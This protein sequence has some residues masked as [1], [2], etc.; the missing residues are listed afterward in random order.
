MTPGKQNWFCM[1]WP[2]AKEAIKTI[3][4]LSKNIFVIG[5]CAVVIAIGNTIQKK[6]CAP[7]S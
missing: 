3:S 2:E 7:E 4:S 1:T 5:A 6:I